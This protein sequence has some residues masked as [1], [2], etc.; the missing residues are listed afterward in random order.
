MIK[1][2]CL[3]L[4]RW[5]KYGSPVIKGYPAVFDLERKSCS[6][7]ERNDSTLYH[8]W[9]VNHLQ[10]VDLTERIIC[11]TRGNPP[12]MEMPP[13]LLVHWCCYLQTEN[14]P[15]L[16]HLSLT[17]HLKR[18]TSSSLVAKSPSLTHQISSPFECCIIILVVSSKCVK[19]ICIAT[20]SWPPH[21]VYPIYKI[22]E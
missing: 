7:I 18:S 16:N 2:R 19:W 20:A 9:A 21:S 6:I 14:I 10:A 17:L 13:L 8:V 1:S 22:F 3:I 11:V 5:R 12:Y 4:A 15:T